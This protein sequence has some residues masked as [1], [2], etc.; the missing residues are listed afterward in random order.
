MA[1]EV[2]PAGSQ[3]L[4]ES[5]LPEQRVVDGKVF[6]FVL[7]PS[8]P[9]PD[10]PTIFQTNRLF[11]EQKLHEHGALFF[12]GFPLRKP[13]DFHSVVESTGWKT[14]SYIGS[15]PRTKIV[16]SVYTA[17]D[18][19]PNIVIPFHHEMAQ[20]TDSWPPKVLFFCETP[21]SEGGQTPIVM[22]HKVTEQ[23][24]I[25]FPKFMQK[26][27]EQGLLYIKVLPMEKDPSQISLQ[28]WPVV[29]G[30]TDQ[31]EAEE[32]AAKHFNAKVEWLPGSK[33]KMVSGP[34]KAI[35]NFGRKGQNMWFNMIIAYH[36]GVSQ[37]LEMSSDQPYD[38]L[39]GDGSPLPA[40]AVEACRKI[41]EDNSVD[42]PWQ[43]GDLMIVDNFAAMHGRRAYK[44][45]RQILVSLCQ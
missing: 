36:S 33:L 32:R 41:H 25:E 19:D 13:S 14:L 39:F 37:K 44:P 8:S 7:S 16:G 10:T 2:L 9:K 26:L 24:W 43:K 28:G 23:M 6:P 38:V 29:F 31:K 5:V 27:E 11:L 22:S 45:P 15:A 18:A 30:T 34:F 20:I 4:V 35:R 21:A 12:R 17:S 1:E 42:I 40:D 3:G